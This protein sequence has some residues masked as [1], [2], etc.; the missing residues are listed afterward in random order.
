MGQSARW[1]CESCQTLVPSMHLRVV[2]AVIN[3]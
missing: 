1:V 3:I 2:C